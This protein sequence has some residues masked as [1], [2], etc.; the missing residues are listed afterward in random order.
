M[1]YT[2]KRQAT[3]GLSQDKEGS[4]RR[5]LKLIKAE[6]E[7]Q[8]VA[9]TVSGGSVVDLQATVSSTSTSLA[10]QEQPETQKQQVLQTPPTGQ[11]QKTHSKQSSVSPV[12]TTTTTT[13]TTSRPTH[14]VKPQHPSPDDR[15]SLVK[16]Q[17]HQPQLLPTQHLK[18]RPQPLQPQP[19]QPQLLRQQSLKPQHRQQCQE[20]KVLQSF[21]VRLQPVTSGPST[22]TATDADLRR[23]VLRASPADVT[24][25]REDVLKVTGAD[26]RRLV[27]TTSSLLIVSLFYIF[28]V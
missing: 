5:K 10:N 4:K 19:L 12:T 18:L 27:T 13:T 21:Q 9:Q 24:E 15:Q 23:V 6:R 1:F 8:V 25:S 14:E 16:Y 28:K 22:S 7:T 11:L 20:R 26:T 2:D 3:Y 17:K